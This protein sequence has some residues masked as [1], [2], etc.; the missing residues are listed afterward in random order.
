M[1][2]PFEQIGRRCSQILLESPFGSL[3]KRELELKLLQAAIDTGALSGE[4]V[5]FAVSL[6]LSLIRANAYLTDLALRKPPLRDVEV[7]A[8]LMSMLPNCEAVVADRFL[9]IPIHDSSLRIWLERKLASELLHPGE[10]VRRDVVK[11]TPQALLRLLDESDGIGSPSAAI[12]RLGKKLPD[13]Q[14]AEAAKR[15][16]GSKTSWTEVLSTFGI[17]I[18]LV[19]ALP[20]LVLVVMGL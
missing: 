10:A 9:S 13:A 12:E 11:L 2:E 5:G 19:E 14:W 17:V 16:W 18:A 4:T 7:V 1:P 15:E 6:R 8:Q 3:S 20:T